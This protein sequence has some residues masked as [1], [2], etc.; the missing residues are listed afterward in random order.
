MK[1]S[2][3]NF[4]FNTYS[5]ALP[6]RNL[7]FYQPPS[8]TV[9]FG[10]PRSE[11]GKEPEI[12]LT[13]LEDGRKEIQELRNNRL[14]KLT[15]VMPSGFY[16]TTTYHHGVGAEHMRAIEDHGDAAGIVS[17]KIYDKKGNLKTETDYGE[18]GNKVDTR[19]YDENQEL[20]WLTTYILMGDTKMLMRHFK[21]AGLS[22][23]PIVYGQPFDVEAFVDGK[24][25]SRLSLSVSE[26]MFKYTQFYVDNPKYS[27]GKNAHRMDIEPRDAKKLDKIDKIL[28]GSIPGSGV[29]YVSL[30]KAILEYYKLAGKYLP[31]IYSGSTL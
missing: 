4:K 28:G 15:E 20:V 22:L 26:Q 1:I 8:D 2:P 12:I 16:T 13:E 10:Q 25:H 5:T 6:S 27:L 11:L 9:S 23:N 31:T 30:D 19:A 7:S 24:L 17:R 14:Y 18:D 3:T 29:S 21:K